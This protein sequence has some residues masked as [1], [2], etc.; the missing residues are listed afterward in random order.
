M[1]HKVVVVR[2]RDQFAQVYPELRESARIH[3]EPDIFHVGL[4]VEYICRD[5]DAKSFSRCLEW[6]KR[7]EKIAVCKLQVATATVCVVMDLCRFEAGAESGV[8]LPDTLVDLLRNEAWLK[9]G[10]G[11]GND[12]AYLS[13]NFDLGQCSGGLD[14]RIV[15]QLRGCRSPNLVDLYASTSGTRPQVRDHSRGTDW[16]QDLT[17]DQVEYAGMDAIMSHRI[18]RYL[19]DALVTTPQLARLDDGGMG[20]VPGP[21]PGPVRGPVPGPAP[22]PAP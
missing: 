16:S 2:S 15:A 10:V 17:M 18:G 21:V 5:N 9:T 19:V 14:V 12:L 7:A 3:R 1:S 20:S 8:N 4:D 13:H 11:I 6:V 22:G